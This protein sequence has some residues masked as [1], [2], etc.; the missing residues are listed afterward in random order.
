MAVKSAVLIG[1]SIRIGY[2]AHVMAAL[3]GQAEIWVPEQN[4]GDSRNVL[5]HLDEWV[6][7]R[8]PDL[9]HVNC[10]LHDLKRA[11]GAGPNVPLEEYA[12]NVRQL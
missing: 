8:A 7:A 1:D 6:L 9:V 12:A 5:A 3:S 4:G 11:F 10:G 2:Q